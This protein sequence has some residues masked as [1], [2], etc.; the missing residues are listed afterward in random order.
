[1]HTVSGSANHNSLAI[2]SIFF[3][4]KDKTSEGRFQAA[5]L[6]ETQTQLR[7]SLI[8]CSVLFLVLVVADAAMGHGCSEF[9]GVFRERVVIAVLAVSGCAWTFWQGLSLQ[10]ARCMASTY[11]VMGMAALMLTMLNQPAQVLWH[12]M[13]MVIML[14]AVY[15]FIPNRL[16]YSLVIAAVASVLFVGLAL[17]IT[18][19]TP[20]EQGMLALLVLS[21]NAFAFVAARRHQVLWRK[22]FRAHAHLQ[23]LSMHDH[24][25]DCFNRR[26][27]HDH[28]LQNEIARARRF[29]QDLTVIM[30]DIDHFKE[31]NDT[32][33]HQ[34]GDAALRYFADVLR[35]LTR[36]NIDSIVRYGGEEFLL[37]LPATNQ[38]QGAALAER[39]RSTLGSHTIPLGNTADVNMTASFGVASVDFSGAASDFTL[40][41][42]IRMADEQLYAAKRDGRNRVRTVQISKEAQVSTP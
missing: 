8:L 15:M 5:Q 39:L 26:Y 19:A 3:E 22:A 35:K 6:C 14:V 20:P 10:A 16:V 42:L 9:C 32:Y 25:T 1:M 41:Y 30:C 7:I 13:A 31:V 28:L 24:L 36:R 18:P 37:I 12:A 2:E 34:A 38:V 29:Q 4:F 21:T 17:T 27:L 33:G 23:K 40:D 11:T